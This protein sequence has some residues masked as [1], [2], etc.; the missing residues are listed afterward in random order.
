LNG[1]GASASSATPAADYR[2]ER[3]GTHSDMAAENPEERERESRESSETNYEERLEE[4]REERDQAAD[5][6]EKNLDSMTRSENG[7][8]SD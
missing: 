8:P 6:L 3:L 1:A 5:E 4:E 7:Q 2:I